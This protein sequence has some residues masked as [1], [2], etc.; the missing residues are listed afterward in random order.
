MEIMTRRVSTKIVDM[1]TQGMTL[2]R[3]HN[4]TESLLAKFR[5]E[6]LKEAADLHCSF[7]SEMPECKNQELCHQRSHMLCPPSIRA[8]VKSVSLGNKGSRYEMHDCPNCEPIRKANIEA[9]AFT[10][11]ATEEIAAL[12]T[13]NEK[14]KAAG[15]EA[16]CGLNLALGICDG[17]QNADAARPQISDAWDM[18]EELL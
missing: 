2:A 12:K 3:F 17:H 6:V 10:D 1:L 9:V 16:M 15:K 5:A 11:M 14:L 7:C 4:E 13:E 18:L 8:D